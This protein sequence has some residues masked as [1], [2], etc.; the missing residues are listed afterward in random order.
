[1]ISLIWAQDDHGLIGK[2]GALPWR[3]PADM[4]W[5]RKRTLGK[6]ILMGRRTYESIGRP[7]PGRLSMI[8]T[9]RTD[10]TAEGCKVV[11]SLDE[12]IATAGNAEEIM[13]IGGAEVYAQ[14]LPLA[15]R[16]YCT[17]IH[18]AFEGDTFFP[19]VDFDQWREEFR[20]DHEADAKNPYSYTFLVMSRLPDA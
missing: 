6:P 20:E 11:H 12:A 10:Y 14:A 3:L 15:E 17:R 9:S 13:V 19:S 8:L 16:L 7:L 5:F 2:E 4:A 18:A 1:M